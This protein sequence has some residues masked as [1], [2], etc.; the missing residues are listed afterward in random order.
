MVLEYLLTEINNTVGFKDI[1]SV[2][3]QLWK[4]TP[5]NLKCRPCWGRTNTLCNLKTFIF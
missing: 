2:F 4:G 1:Q 3:D 5:G